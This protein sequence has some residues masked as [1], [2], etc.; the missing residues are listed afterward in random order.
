M[1]PEYNYNIRDKWL[2]FNGFSPVITDWSKSNTTSLLQ[3]CE[4]AFISKLKSAEK[5]YY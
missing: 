1:N 2:P 5:R 3:A 4:R